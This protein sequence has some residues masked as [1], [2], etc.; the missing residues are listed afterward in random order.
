MPEDQVRLLLVAA[1]AGDQ[2]ARN[3]LVLAN[4][5]LIFAVVGEFLKTED[6]SIDAMDLVQTGI[7]D[8]LYK[9]IEKFDLSQPVK[10]STYAVHWIHQ[11]MRDAL[12]KQWYVLNIP[13]YIFAYQRA[14]RAASAKHLQEHGTYPDHRKLARQLNIPWPSYVLCVRYDREYSLDSPLSAFPHLVTRQGTGARTLGEYLADMLASDVSE[15]VEEQDRRQ[16]LLSLVVKAG[17]TERESRVLHLR[18]IQGMSLREAG[19]IL[20][21]SRTSVANVESRA[22]VK[23][24]RVQMYVQ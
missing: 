3:T 14:I 22:L 9:A 15:E 13:A 8:G 12:Y 17:L 18:F 1:Q 6:Q 16:L 2:E 5:R 11:V 20:N 4:L 24:R 7:L 19:K 23:L 21:L 10:F